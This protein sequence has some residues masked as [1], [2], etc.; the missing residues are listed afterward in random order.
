MFSTYFQQKNKN[1]FS[2]EDKFRFKQS[3]S[4][5]FLNE[6]LDNIDNIIDVLNNVHKLKFLQIII[7]LIRKM[8]TYHSIIR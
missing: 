6:I 5:I 7:K 3:F 4:I 1:I 2:H 8:N